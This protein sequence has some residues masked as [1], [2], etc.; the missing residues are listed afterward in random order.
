MNPTYE[1]ILAEY[2]DLPEHH[3]FFNIT[4]EFDTQVD[5]MDDGRGEIVV[6]DSYVEITIP[7]GVVG[8]ITVEDLVELGDEFLPESRQW[9]D[10][11][12]MLSD[13]S[14]ELNDDLS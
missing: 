11:E 6:T 14:A 7:V 9:A 3:K 10:V 13:F 1:L 5:Y 2:F 12:Q 4:M 8:A